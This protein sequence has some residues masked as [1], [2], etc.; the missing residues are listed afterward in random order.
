MF[1]V[2]ILYSANLDRFYVGSTGNLE[3]RIARHN[4]GRSK[5]TKG[6]K[7]WRLVYQEQFPTK[8]EA[9]KREL[10]IKSWKSRTAIESL[11]ARS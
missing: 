5:S 1:F 4:G 2:Y 10:Q 6:G 11:I 9:C 3:D 7:P 8:S